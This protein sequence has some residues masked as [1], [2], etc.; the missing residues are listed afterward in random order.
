MDHN[1]DADD[2]L[3]PIPVPRRSDACHVVEEAFAEEHEARALEAE[4]RAT[5]PVAIPTLETLRNEARA[6]AQSSQTLLDRHAPDWPEHKFTQGVRDTAAKLVVEIQRQ[7]D[8]NRKEPDET[9]EPEPASRRRG[10]R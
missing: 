8:A 5:Y 6:L 10:G 1:R 3:R 9:P 7:L 2:G 4:V